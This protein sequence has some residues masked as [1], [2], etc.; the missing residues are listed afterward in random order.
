MNLDNLYPHAGNHSIQNAILAIE[1]GIPLTAQQVAT[2]REAGTPVLSSYPRVE[3][4]RS[5]VVNIGSQP[6][7]I[8]T[9]AS[10][11]SGF[12]FSRFSAGGIL[13]KQ[14]QLNRANC[15]FIVSDY[16][17]WASLVDELS[18]LLSAISPTLFAHNIPITAVGL[19]YADRF[20]W[21]GTPSDLN[22]SEV[23]RAGSPYIALNGLSC[24][25]SWHSHHGYFVNSGTP[26]EH[27]R[28]DNINLNIMDEQQG[29]AIQIV[30]SHRAILTTPLLD[31]NTSQNSQRVVALETEMH[32]V[33]KRLFRQLLTDQLLAKIQ[34]GEEKPT[35]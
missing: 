26:V 13:E 18:A 33:N 20:L 8:P 34:L 30:T 6:N 23:F 14:V 31:G 7:A 21:R 35:T 4:Q 28:L 3:E 27:R 19:Q 1:W 16:S 22:L 25:D 29:R 2:L 9:Q 10:E 32:S 12:A 24:A 17:R 5:I 11:T 15:L